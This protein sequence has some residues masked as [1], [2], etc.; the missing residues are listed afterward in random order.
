LLSPTL[1]GIYFDKLEDCFEKECCVDS[2][3]TSIVIN[4]FIYDNDIVL[5]ERIPH[6]LEN[7]LRILKDFYSNK[8]MSVNTHKTK[9]MV[10]KSNKIPYDTFISDN[11]NLEEVHSYTYLRI[12]I[13]H[14]INWNY[15]IEKRIIGGCKAYYGLENNCKSVDLWSWDKNKVLFETHVTPTILYGCEV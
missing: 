2:T 10:I 12:D 15:S 6:D 4:I 5:M 9:V 14:K 13:H 7:Q 3:L 11:N 8:G 1:F